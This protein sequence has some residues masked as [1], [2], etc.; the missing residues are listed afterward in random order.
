[1][2]RD[3]CWKLGVN[4]RK[5]RIKV[6]KYKNIDEKEDEECEGSWRMKGNR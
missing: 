4:N 3:E 1:M 5:K 2:R 6:E